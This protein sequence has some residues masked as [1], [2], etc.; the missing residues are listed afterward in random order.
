M[1]TMADV[2]KLAGVS[3]STVSYAL[4][5]ARPISE[6]TRERVLWAVEQLDFQPNA[7]AR[8]LAGRRTGFL[9]LLIPTDEAIT[10]P[11]MVDIIVAAAEAARERGYHL[12][13]WTE[14]AGESTGV[15]ELMRR[16]LIDGALLL[17]VRLH[18]GRVQALR[19]ADV[20]LTMIGRTQD[21]GDC[22][23]VDSDAEQAAEVAIALLADLGHKTVAFVGPPQSAYD[24]GVGIVVRI[25]DSLIESA[26]R[27]GIR[28]LPAFAD[29]SAR[30]SA[31]ALTGLIE[32]EP[33]V[34]AVVALDDAAIAGILESLRSLALSV[35]T[36]VS[37]VGLLISPQVAEL[38]WPQVT[39]VAHNPGELGRL[40][41][42]AMIDSLDGSGDP[43]TQTLVPS[44]VVER[45]TTAPRSA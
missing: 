21:P 17:S 14:P 42:L 26:E 25:H 39:T 4:S 33:D 6:S 3:V 27:R 43:I 38:A 31:H 30:A 36:D 19:E 28:L 45:S 13:L 24:D 12:L 9:A 35:P 5:G 8:G 32:S 37:I 34:T 1:A 40:A 20:P 18:D 7:M 10:D 41:A 29:R 15:K 16:G 11:F 22:N 2:A 44:E 23:Y